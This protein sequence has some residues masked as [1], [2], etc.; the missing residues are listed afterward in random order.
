MLL[1]T[2]LAVATTGSIS[3]MGAALGAGL[4][5]V[6]AGIGIGNI[7]S[8]AMKAI[9]RQPEE[10]N[11]IRMNMFIVAAL[12]EGVALFAIVLCLLAL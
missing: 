11:K 3:K 6:G 10:T 4:A 8:S 5:A 2:I 1:S 7:G 9:A 12:V